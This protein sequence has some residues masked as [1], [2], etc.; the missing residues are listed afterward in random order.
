M[1][2][3]EG[4][5]DVLNAILSADLMAI[6]QYFVHAKLCEYWV[7]ER[8]HHKVRA[9]SIDVMKDADR[10]IG[11]ILYLENVP[12]V[13]RLATVHLGESVSEQ[14]K[15]DLKAEQDMLMLLTEGVR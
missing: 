5:I 10:L 1:K 8:L 11:H 2:A 15:F 6:N 7:Y 4:V 3:K 9:R 12:R 13:H 14:L